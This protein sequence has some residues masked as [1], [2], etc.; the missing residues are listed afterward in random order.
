MENKITINEVDLRG[1]IG[2][3]HTLLDFIDVDDFEDE[4]NV[5]LVNCGYDDFV[6]PIIKAMRE[7][8]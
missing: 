5:D 3:V 2:Y 1:L 7:E 4:E 8:Q 6:E